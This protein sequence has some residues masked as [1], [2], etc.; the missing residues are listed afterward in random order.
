VTVAVDLIHIEVCTVQAP[1]DALLAPDAEEWGRAEEAVVRVEPTPLDRQPSAYVQAAW[2][3]RPRSGIGEL[4]VRAAASASAFAVRLDW[5]AVRPSR[6]ISDVNVYPDGCAVIFPADGGEAEFSTMGSPE[7]PVQ[8][9]HWRAG[10][11]APFV[12]TA[13]GIGTVERAAEHQVEGRARWTDGRWQVVLARPLGGNGVPLRERSSM[14]VAFAVWLGAARERAGLK[15]YS[16]QPCELR[17]GSGG[18]RK[19]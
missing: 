10:T 19:S 15:S 12:V 9:W 7:H 1:L 4:R 14:P 18:G 2:R 17:L 5:A 13:T 16:P 3:D 8:A 11:E 6:L